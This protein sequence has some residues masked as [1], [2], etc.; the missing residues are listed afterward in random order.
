MK[1][2]VCPLGNLRTVCVSQTFCKSVAAMGEAEMV[3]RFS[4]PRFGAALS[5][6]WLLA[7]GCRLA[8]GFGTMALL[9]AV[10]PQLNEVTRKSKS[11]LASLRKLRSAAELHVARTEISHG[12]DRQLSRLGGLAI[13]N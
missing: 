5:G 7:S 3:L 2:C 6:F 11:L 8:S 1:S 13:R 10:L 12:G 9:V 4:A